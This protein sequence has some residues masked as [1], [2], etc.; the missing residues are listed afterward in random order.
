MRKAEQSKTKMKN[1]LKGP[2]ELQ[3]DQTQK[4]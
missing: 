4:R 3:G 1:V 2:R